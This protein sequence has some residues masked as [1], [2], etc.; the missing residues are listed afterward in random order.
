MRESSVSGSQPFTS[1]AMRGGPASYSLAEAD[2]IMSA[3]YSEKD[4][5][6]PWRDADLPVFGLSRTCNAADEQRPQSSC[7]LYCCSCGRLIDMSVAGAVNPPAAACVYCAST[8]GW[9]IPRQVGKAR[10]CW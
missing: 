10:G 9:G 3:R 4:S 5:T 2:L 8:H 6:P 7:E 1:A